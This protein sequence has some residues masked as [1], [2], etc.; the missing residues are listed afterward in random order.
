MM[1]AVGGYFNGEHIVMD[2][3]IG[4]SNGDR[5]IVTILEKKSK[6]ADFD[7]DFDIMQFKGACKSRRGIDA[8]EYVRSL[9]DNDRL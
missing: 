2:E 8:T 6:K 9:R 7:P 4:L 5:V 1:Q 3:N